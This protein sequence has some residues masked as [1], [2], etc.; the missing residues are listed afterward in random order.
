M[1]DL[2]LVIPAKHESESLPIFL[3]EISLFSCK[4]IIVLDKNDFKTIHAIKDFN[5][6][7]VF[8]QN[9][10]SVLNK[11]IFSTFWQLWLSGG[12]ERSGSG[13]CGP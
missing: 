6:I 8:M 12:L 4:K 13:G 5:K 10:P 7:D 3:K 2:T 9:C 1:Q 11:S